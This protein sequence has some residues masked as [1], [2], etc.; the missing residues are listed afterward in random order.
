MRQIIRL[1]EK[2]EVCS[3]KDWG[4]YQGFN[5]CQCGQYLWVERKLVRTQRCGQWGNDVRF[6]YRQG[7]A[8]PENYP[9][10]MAVTR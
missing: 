3:A 8:L 1:A 7:P 6:P 4:V 10:W 9:G 2:C 5:R